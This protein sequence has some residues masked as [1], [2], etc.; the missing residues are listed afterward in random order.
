[1]RNVKVLNHRVGQLERSHA[2]MKKDVRAEVLR[3]WLASLNP[4]VRFFVTRFVV[5]R[6]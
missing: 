1:M 5:A 2:R 4:V 6:L 3:D